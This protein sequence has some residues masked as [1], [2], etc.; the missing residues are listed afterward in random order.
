MDILRLGTGLAALIVAGCS[1]EGATAPI[2][3]WPASAATVAA[4][5]VVQW[6]IVGSAGNF[7]LSGLS[8]SSAA[9][10]QVAYSAQGPTA[11]AI[12]RLP[13]VGQIDFRDG[14]ELVGTP[15]PSDDQASLARSVSDMLIASPLTAT[16][17]APTSLRILGGS[18]GSGDAGAP[19]SGDSSSSDSAPDSADAGMNESSDGAAD[20]SLEGGP[21]FLDSGDAAPDSSQPLTLGSTD[22]GPIALTY[23]PDGGARLTSP[24][25]MCAAG[26][27]QSAV[28]QS[29][30]N[31]G[32]T[33]GCSDTCDGARA[34]LAVR[35][36][37]TAV[38]NTN[39]QGCEGTMNPVLANDATIT[40]PSI[41]DLHQHAPSTAPSDQIQGKAA[42]APGVCGGAFLLS[43]A[44]VAMGGLDSDG[45]STN[46]PNTSMT[47]T[48]SPGVS[49]VTVFSQIQL[50]LGP[51][52]TLPQAETFVV[53]NGQIS[54]LV[55]V[56]DNGR[57]LLA[58]P[59]ILTLKL[60]GSK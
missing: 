7:Q 45:H 53:E 16:G 49:P 44:E 54:S 27:P 28:L 40:A 37:Y 36:Y 59:Y 2:V 33:S 31:C 5:G 55:S 47:V 34:L 21:P 38:H 15:L 60:T 48:S 6:E 12:F 57:F 19:D 13:S 8:A 35:R 58:L 51:Y 20:A 18:G 46:P 50:P 14:R 24:A 52:G 3:A 30:A 17:L 25:A 9:V 29:I 26:E 39:A 11:T 4:S 23:A 42:F 41:S 32:Q 22:G 10:V 43:K 56:Y 1:S